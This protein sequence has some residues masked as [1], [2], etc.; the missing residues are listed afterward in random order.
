MIT[1]VG[2]LG[3]K[4]NAQ[5]EFPNGIQTKAYRDSQGNW[6]G[7][8]GILKKRDGSAVKQGDTWTE[9][10]A[11]F[12][13]VAT[14]QEFAD[15]VR[16]CLTVEPTQNQFDALFLLA[17]NIGKDGRESF[18]TS[19]AL[20]KH[21]E[22]RFEEAAEAFTLWRWAG[23][24]ND[25]LFNRLDRGLHVPP[26][27]WMHGPGIA[28]GPPGWSPRQPIPRGVEWKQAL[29]GLYRRHASEGLLYL[30]LDWAEACADYNI[31]LQATT[32]WQPDHNRWFDRIDYQTPW[33]DILSRATP[34][35]PEILEPAPFDSP[36]LAIIPRGYEEPEPEMQPRTITLPPEWDEMTSS[37]K[38]PW[39]NT[40][41]LIRLGGDPATPGPD[42]VWAAPALPPAPVAIQRRTVAAPNVD[43]SAPPKAMEDS[44]THRGLSKA[45]SGREIAAVGGA[46]GIIT[47]SLPLARD[48]TG[49][50]EAVQM[51]TLLTA[52][53]CFGVILIGV[54]L[55][56]WWRGNIIA[57]EG[58]I[59]G[60]QPK[61]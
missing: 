55:W 36:D 44:E 50:F 24:D 47:A 8:G 41:E 32:L 57:Y 39:L 17:W 11:W 22:R 33:E 28:E 49:F 2:L 34:I 26:E 48:L 45:E 18:I 37:E 52:G 60:T 1:R 31:E 29:R 46:A 3:A 20:R 15:F 10:E 16:A 58:R 19:T 43:L 14:R 21:N 27:Q 4:L 13:Y 40:G 7:P 61:V 35:V 23:K 25:A 9:E 6:T 38:T 5:Y 51:K 53:L 42:P 12:D 56:R 54:G 59:N 30:G